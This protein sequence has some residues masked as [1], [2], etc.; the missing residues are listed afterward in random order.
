M[1]RVLK[2]WH[3]NEETAKLQTSDSSGPTKG[4]QSMVPEPIWESAGD[5][6]SQ[7][8]RLR[9]LPDNPADRDLLG[10]DAIAFAVTDVV[11]A[12]NPEPITVGLHGPWGSGKSSLLGYVRAALK[13]RNTTLVIDINPWEFDG[14]EDVRGTVIATVLDELGDH[15]EAGV[16][17]KLK[18]LARR[19]SWSRAV[20]AVANGALTMTWDI[21]KLVDALTPRPE[22]GPPKTLA[23]FRRE[24]AAVM[25]EVEV[26]RV[27]ILIDDLDRCLPEAVL[28]TLEAVKL[29]LAVPKMAFIIAAD[30]AMIREAITVG[31]GE[32]RRSVA[33]ARDYLDKIVQVPIAVPQPTHHDAECYVALLLASLEADRPLDWDTLLTH[34]EGRRGDGFTPYLLDV[35]VVG[36]EPVH[37]HRAKQ[38]VG[39]LA[40]DEAV[41]PRRIKRFINALTVRQY[42]AAASGVI[43]DPAV[44]AKLFMLEH[45]FESHLRSLAEKSQ[46]E[47]AAMLSGWEAWARGDSEGTIEPDGSDEDLRDLLAT[48]PS[49]ADQNTEEYFVLARKLLKSR[50]T[51]GLSEAS[52]ECLG[53]LLED[54]AA[55]RTRGATGFRALSPEERPTVVEELLTNSAIQDDPSFYFRAILEIADDIGDPTP[56]IEAIKA[57]RNKL[58]PGVGFLL[59]TSQVES[60]AALS[61]ELQSDTTVPERTRRAIRKGDG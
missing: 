54:D 49:L 32:T 52:R 59:C 45:R 58:T 28:S 1:I 25:T 42:T 33:F 15:S 13:S 36:L 30:Q 19:V 21:D 9:V 35:G 43:L 46:T 3:S 20:L 11:C 48:E 31:L 4:D 2:S 10:L 27:V 37:L 23:G 41:N 6:M 38:I 24:F 61:M 55:V 14:R 39:G 50:F 5:M 8:P 51:A 56:A 60:V 29:F 57:R 40:S 47:R 17:E 18:S 34:A 53:L 16:S 12:E 26:N 22:S 44:I 7:T